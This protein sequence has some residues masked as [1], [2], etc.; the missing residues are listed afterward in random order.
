MILTL[1]VAVTEEV[2]PDSV[3][4]FDT[5]IFADAFSAVGAIASEL[6][7]LPSIEYASFPSSS[8]TASPFTV[9]AE[10]PQLF[11]TAVSEDFARRTVFIYG[12]FSP[13]PSL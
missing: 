7:S 11:P 8:E 1:S 13:V 4:L 3:R 10:S 5:Y 12:D 9:S 6:A 2:F